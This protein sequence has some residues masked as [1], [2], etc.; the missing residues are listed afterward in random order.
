[1]S[2]L[3]NILLTAAIVIVLMFAS[4]MIKVRFTG[5]RELKIKRD[6]EEN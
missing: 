2:T 1:M 6:H 5:K 3:F 4:G